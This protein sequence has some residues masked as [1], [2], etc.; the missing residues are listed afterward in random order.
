MPTKRN[1][2]LVRNGGT[3]ISGPAMIG[4]SPLVLAHGSNGVYDEIAIFGG[5]G[6]IIIALIYL[7]WKA[8]RDKKRREERRRRRKSQS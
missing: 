2:N 1:E 7:S 6:L 5:I 8:G 3:A 4:V